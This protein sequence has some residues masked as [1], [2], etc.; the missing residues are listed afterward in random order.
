MR[1]RKRVGP[2]K[3]R[4]ATRKKA[5]KAAPKKK[6]RALAVSTAVELLGGE[7]PRRS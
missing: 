6:K 7:A 3:R 1:K 4:P 5:R 2:P